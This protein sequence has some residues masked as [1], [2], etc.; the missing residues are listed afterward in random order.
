MTRLLEI[1]FIIFLFLSILTA[2]ILVV[3][4]LIGLV[5][6][7]GEFMIQMNDLL[8][9]PAIV[10]AAVFAAAAFILGYLPKYKKN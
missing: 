5:I 1:I 10:F 4:Q 9:T 2:L 6:Q 7:N 3:S 8:L